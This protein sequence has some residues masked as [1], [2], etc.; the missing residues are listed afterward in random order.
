MRMVR[1]YNQSA[2]TLNLL[3]AF[4]NGGYADL[5]MINKWNLDFIS[6]SPQG[7]RYQKLSERIEQA[8]DFMTACRHDRRKNSTSSNAQIFHLPR[9]TTP[10]YEEA[11]TRV[12]STTGDWYDCSGH[13]V[14][15]GARTNQEDHAQIEFVRGIKNPIGMKCPPSTT[16]DEL[17]RLI[18]KI[19]PD[20]EAGRLT[21]ISRMGAGKYSTTCPKWP[22]G[23][24]KKAALS[25][26][27]TTRCM[28]TQQNHRPDIK[29][30]NSIRC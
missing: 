3:R 18:D 23:L 8:L 13:F 16:P 15:I 14:W 7:E 1:A 20:N 21:L 27:Y 6:D 5:Y 17:I 28:A 11:L 29:P 12:D 2:A 4:A 26:G 19:N 22:D 25:H 24:K 9:S 10:S 30:A